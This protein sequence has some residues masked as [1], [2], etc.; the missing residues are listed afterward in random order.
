MSDLERR[1]LRLVFVIAASAG[2]AARPA[3]SEGDGRVDPSHAAPAMRAHRD[4]TT[5]QFT[6]PPA[7]A[8]APVSA[9]QMSAQTAGLVETPGPYGGTMVRV[10][11][12]FASDVVATVKDGTVTANCVDER[13]P[14]ARRDTR[15]G[16]ERR[17]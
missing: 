1:L 12:R 5:Q 16:G 15:A 11:G 3:P 17:P 2:C 4:P 9:S 6:A 8:P 10:R 7:G 14:N 13:S